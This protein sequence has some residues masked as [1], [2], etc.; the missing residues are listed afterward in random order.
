MLLNST[1]SRAQPPTKVRQDAYSPL[2][3]WWPRFVGTPSVG[4]ARTERPLQPPLQPPCGVLPNMRPEWL[5]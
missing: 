1:N 2:A 5:S 3:H 4:D